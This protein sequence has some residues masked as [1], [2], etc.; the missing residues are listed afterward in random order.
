M[1]GTFCKTRTRFDGCFDRA[2]LDGALLD[3]ALADGDG[4]RI[5]SALAARRIPFAFLTAYSRSEVDRQWADR[6]YVEKPFLEADVHRLVRNF[7]PP[8]AG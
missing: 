6:A 8:K 4:Y 1:R 2:T 3:I 5:A 7:L